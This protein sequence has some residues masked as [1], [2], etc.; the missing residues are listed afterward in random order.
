MPLVQQ[1]APVDL[2]KRPPDRLDVALVE[3]AVGVVEVDPEADPLGQPVPLLQVGE[4]RLAAARV[5]LADPVLLDFGLRFDPQLLFDGDLHRQSMAIP[6][7]LALDEVT[8]HR[9]KARVDVLEHAREHVVGTRR[10]VGRRRTLVEVPALRARADTQRLGEHVALAPALEHLQLELGQLAPRVD[11]AA[12]DQRVSV[13][14]RHGRPILGAGHRLL[15]MGLCACAS[16]T[17]T[18]ARASPT[19]SSAPGRRSRCCTPACSRTW[20]G[21]RPS[22]RSPIA[23]ASCCP[24]CRCTAT[25]RTIRAIRTRS[26]GSP[27]CSAASRARCSAR[28]R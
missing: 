19:A 10:A 22:A 2:R 26:T 1:L 18:T 24:I 13:L 3:R 20:S 17:T 11:L 21:S 16:T 4:H 14:C 5:E 9:L 15:T 8:A 28:G 27:R 25:P 12:R 23:S 7:A 6:A